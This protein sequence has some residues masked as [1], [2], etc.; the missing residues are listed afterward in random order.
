MTHG[1]AWPRAAAAALALLAAG[2]V[3]RLLAGEPGAPAR[4]AGQA[5]PTFRSGVDLVAAQRHGDRP[6]GPVRHRPRRRG[7]RGLRGR[8]RSRTLAFF[9]RT[10]LPCRVSLLLDTSASMEDKMATAQEAAAGL[11]RRVSGPRTRRRSSTSTAASRVVSAVHH[12]KAATSS[13]R[14]ASTAPGGSTSLY[15]ADLHRAQGAE[16][17]P[18]PRGTDDLRRQAIV[19]LSDGEDTSSLVS[20]DEVLELA[21]RSETAIYAIGLSRRSKGTTARR[22]TRRTSSL[23]QLTTQTGG[24]VFFPST[25]D[26]LRSIYALISEELS[27]QY[28]LGYT[29]RTPKRDGRWRR[30]VVRARRPG[31]ARAPSRATTPRGVMGY[32]GSRASESS[33]PALAPPAVRSLL[34]PLVAASSLTAALPRARCAHA[35]IVPWS[36]SSAP[37]P[38]IPAC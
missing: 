8:R 18:R 3:P 4:P 28:L 11:R 13:R 30:I 29:S 17:D 21:K 19:V 23:R 16:E 20:L 2:A 33:G 10:N 14:F 31:A 32:C 35:R 1:R 9:S 37:A 12:S 15:N 36:T 34:L 5:A 38:A 6:V 25:A 27:S 22:P 7:L 26:E 24:R